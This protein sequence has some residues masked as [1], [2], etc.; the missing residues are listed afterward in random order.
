MTKKLQVGSVLDR[1]F[2]VKRLIQAGGMGSVYEVEDALQP[3]VRYAMKEILPSKNPHSFREAK[4]RFI[5]EIQVMQSM[6]HANIPQIVSSFIARDNFYFVMDYIDG[7]NLSAYKKEHGN[8]GFEVGLVIGWMMQVLEALEYLHNLTPPVVHRDIKPSNMLLQKDGRVILIDFGISTAPNPEG[9]YWIGTPG[10][11]APEQQM[12]H[13][14]AASDLYSL[15]ASAHELITGVRPN[16]SMTFA[17]FKDFGVE[18]S[19]RLQRAFDW[20]LEQ[21]PQERVPSAKKLKQV[22]AEAGVSYTMPQAC[23][24]QSFEE[25]VQLLKSEVV[26]PELSAWIERFGNECQTSF[27]PKTLSLLTFTLGVGTPYRLIIRKDMVSQELVFE[28]KQGLLESLSLGRVD[29]TRPDAGRETL[30]LLQSYLKNYESYKSNSWG[31][32]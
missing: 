3:Q 4:S 12:G 32:V 8:P 10:Y 7:I 18:V 1:R 16:N 28:E 25:A 27:V 11:A 9:N 19:S 29:P 13:P 2:K 21:W 20:A 23:S 17:P 24:R 30:A 14:S 31:I 6:S 5:G 26:D 22:L 15:A